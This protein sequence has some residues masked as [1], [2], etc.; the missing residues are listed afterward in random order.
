MHRVIAV[1][2]L[3][4][5]LCPGILIARLGRVNG[6]ERGERGRPELNRV[7]APKK[8]GSKSGS[9]R[10]SSLPRRSPAKIAPS[11]TGWR[12]ADRSQSGGTSQV[13]A[14]MTTTVVATHERLR[15]EQRA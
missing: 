8:V 5:Y 7:T 1:P 11:L 2:D 15:D 4:I 9:G 13:N 12:P 6:K 14:R 3:R 10:S